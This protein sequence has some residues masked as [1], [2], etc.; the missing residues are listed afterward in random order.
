MQIVQPFNVRITAAEYAARFSDP[1]IAAQV[2]DL[3]A[4]LLA[5]HAV[6]IVRPVPSISADD[7]LAD[8][9]A[10][11]AVAAPL[12]SITSALARRSELFG[13]HVA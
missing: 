9:A 11:I 1:A 5:Y 13:A 2:A 7:L 4:K 12:P 6:K 10:R 8:M 3:D